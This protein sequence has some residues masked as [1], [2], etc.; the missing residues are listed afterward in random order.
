MIS[1]DEITKRQE[2]NKNIL[3]A[4]SQIKEGKILG[5]NVLIKLLYYEVETTTKNGVIE[6]RY[7]V[8]ETEGGRPG[9]NIDDTPWQRRGVVVKVGDEVTN[10]IKEGDFVWVS[11]MVLRDGF[12]FL[13]NPEHPVDKPCGYK[14]VPVSMIELIEKRDEN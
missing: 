9:V 4:P 14:R 13:I 7:K 12:D 5:K 10:D 1:T 2:Y 8:F 11:P 3:D 6:P